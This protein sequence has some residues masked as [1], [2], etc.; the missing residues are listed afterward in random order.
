MDTF[1]YTGTA[2]D[3]KLLLADGTL[4]SEDS[5]Q[6][7]SAYEVRVF[8]NTRLTYRAWWKGHAIGAT[9]ASVATPKPSLRERL[10]GWLA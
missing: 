9:D 5:F 10:L 6:V 2:E 8:F 7:I 4:D 1:T 3:R